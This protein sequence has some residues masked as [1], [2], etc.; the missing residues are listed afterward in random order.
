MLKSNRLFLGCKNH[1]KRFTSMEGTAFF[2]DDAS[3][4]EAL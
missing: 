3:G 1:K 4:L 2:M